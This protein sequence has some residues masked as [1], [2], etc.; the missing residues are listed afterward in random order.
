MRAIQAI[1]HE[2]RPNAQETLG[3]CWLDLP[4][5]LLAFLCGAAIDRVG[6][7]DKSNEG[8]GAGIYEWSPV[9]LEQGG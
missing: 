4:C 8:E 7:L 9:L 3:C 2:I 1:K 5:G 6:S